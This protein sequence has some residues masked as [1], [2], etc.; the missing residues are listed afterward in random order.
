MARLGDRPH[1]VVRIALAIHGG[2]TIRRTQYRQAV[3]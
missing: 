2:E 1:D 3:F